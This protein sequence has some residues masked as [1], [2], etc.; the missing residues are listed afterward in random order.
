M[1]ASRCL[2]CQTPLTLRQRAAGEAY[3]CGGCEVARQ[4]LSGLVDA[5]R[6]DALGG[7]PQPVSSTRLDDAVIEELAARVPTSGRARVD[8]DVEGVTCASCT[9]LIESVAKKSAG[10]QGAV[11]QTAL[12]RLSLDVDAAR[13]DVRALAGTLAQLGHSVGPAVREHDH[14]SD[15]LVA[16]LGVT[17]ALASAAMVF[18][19]SFYFGL[20]AQDE[21]GR[22]FTWGQAIA[23][24]LAVLVG[25]QPFF[26]AARAA[27]SAHSLT[28]DVPI[29]LGMV[30]ALVA[31]L[32][33]VAV[34]GTGAVYFDTVSV[35]VTLMLIGRLLERRVVEHNRRLLLSHDSDVAGLTVRRA[36]QDG[37]TAHVPVS[38]LRAGD[39]ITVAPGELVPV[40]A[41]LL[42]SASDGSVPSHQ[43]SRQVS[44]A[45]ITGE[46]EAHAVVQGDALPAGAHNADARALQCRV[47]APFASSR[48]AA[49]LA[50]PSARAADAFFVRLARAW[51]IG[52]FAVAALAVALWWSAG[53][54]AVLGV[55]APLLVVT[56]PCAFGIAAPL[57]IERALAVLR[58]AGVFVKSPTFL[59]RARKLKTI[60]FD[61]TGTLT[62]GALELFDRAPLDALTDRERGALAALTSASNHP[63]SRALAAALARVRPAA[64][65][66]VEEPGVGVQSADGRFALQRAAD[67]NEDAT[68]FLADGVVRA[69]FSFREQLRA[70]AVDELKRLQALGLS[71]YIT[72][73]DDAARTQAMAR[74]LGIP[75]ENAWGGLL[76]E[77]KREKVRALD[78]GDLLYVGDGLNDALAFDAATCAGTPAIDRPQLPARADF[79]LLGGTLEAL[80]DVVTVARRL[81][82][83]LVGLLGVATLYNAVVIA[84]ALA[85]ALTP[86]SVALVMPAMSLSL[87]SAAV[88][89]TRVPARAHEQAPM[90][91]STH[92]V[93]A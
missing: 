62:S 70:G 68:V 51:V 40:D 77:Q 85:G 12:G 10:V 7:A 37:T 44:L 90:L 59:S 78:H 76:P 80:G 11:L 49:L 43:L 47:T 27:L 36:Q 71:L 65:D 13:F 35:F 64:L 39:V 25:G 87:V 91:Q 60:V 55:L 34:G 18:A 45:W 75:Q 20:D 81:R 6:F 3:C 19:F 30:L 26:R 23:G 17:A 33:Q 2:H 50:P 46:P 82:A 79:F 15:E 72:S 38:A 83:V 29:S 57:A 5:R 42:G 54:L 56:C 28:M 58:R 9:W 92:E 1:I 4:V 66:V 93:P 22:V 63:K 8:L 52:V 89:L 53:A 48:L 86:L 32:A 24:V 73:G 14:V 69:R 67:A 16:R 61:K 84:C 31:S 88:A 74:R 41:T 21:I